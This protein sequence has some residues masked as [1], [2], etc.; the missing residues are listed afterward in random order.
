MKSLAQIC[1]TSFL[2][3][4]ATSAQAD[5]VLTGMTVFGANS[6]GDTVGVNR[7]DTSSSVPNF[8]L[9][10]TNPGQ[11]IAGSFANSGDGANLAP[12]ITLA[13]GSNSIF[14]FGTPGVFADFFGAN[15]YFDGASTPG[16]SVFAEPNSSSTPP[17]PDFF[18]NSSALTYN[19]DGSSVAGSGTLAFTNGTET[20][21]LSQFA[22]SLPT[23][24]GL[25][26]VSAYDIFPDGADDFVGVL[27]FNVSAVPEPSSA[28]LLLGATPFLA[29]RRR[30]C[31]A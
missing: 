24:F 13:T 9:Y 30:E 23:T 26:R 27:T 25:D 8:N 31:K 7:W 18:A 11:P 1:F 19:L 16:I 12:S 15:F 14:V 10:L 3:F 29:F 6:S 22:W 4:F 17:F 2:V 28:L 20:A 21:T 5:I